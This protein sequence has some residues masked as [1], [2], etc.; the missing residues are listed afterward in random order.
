[1]DIFVGVLMDEGVWL[2]L[3]YVDKIKYLKFINMKYN[4]LSDEMKKEL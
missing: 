1:M 2:L 3:D 4:Y